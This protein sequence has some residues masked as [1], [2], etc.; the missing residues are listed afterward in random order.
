MLKPSFVPERLLYIIKDDE[1]SIRLPLT[2]IFL[3]GF[4]DIVFT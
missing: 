2:F 3:T 4:D 1:S